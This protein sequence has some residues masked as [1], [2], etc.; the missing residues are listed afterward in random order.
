L[1]QNSIWEKNSRCWQPAC[2]R[3]RGKERGEASQPFLAAGRQ[4][5][6]RQSVCEFLETLGP[7]ASEKSIGALLEID[8]FLAHAVCQPVMLI[9]AHPA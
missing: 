5:L 9:E 1:S 3:S 2:L 4:I 6:G 8:A 7:P